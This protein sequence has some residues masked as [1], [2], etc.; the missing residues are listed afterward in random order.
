MHQQSFSE[1]QGVSPQR[2]AP[3]QRTTRDRASRSSRLSRGSVCCCL[4]PPRAAPLWAW[5]LLG[6]LVV[7]GAWSFLS[8][9]QEELLVE[10]HNHYRGQVSPS[11]SAM[12]PLVRHLQPAELKISMCSKQFYVFSFHFI[13]TFSY[14]INIIPE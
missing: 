8:E 10:L 13:M 6:T 14:N 1:L 9:E 3:T 12:L 2:G 7:P 5:L 4:C 11:A